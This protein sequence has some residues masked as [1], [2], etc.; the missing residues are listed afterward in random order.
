MDLFLN[1]FVNSL[2]LYKVHI[3]IFFLAFLVAL[4]VAHPQFLVTDEWVTANQL[5]QLNEGH[6]LILNEGKYGSFENGTPSQYFTAKQNYLAYSLILPLVSLPAEWLVYSFGDNFLMCIVYLWTFLLIAL[7]L[8]LNAFF[9]QFTYWGK[10][11]WTP[12]LIVAAF[13]GFF[14]NLYYYNS[15]LLNGPHSFPEILAIVFTNIILFAFLAVM[16][17]DILLMIFE[18]P[19]YAIFGTI[20]CLS[21]SSYLFWTNFC[22]DHALIAFLFTAVLLMIIK[23]L[24]TEYP[25][26]LAGGFLLCGLLVWARPELGFFI[27]LVMCCFAVYFSFGIQKH[28]HT[29]S[30]RIR[31]FLIPLCVIIG[32]IPF[33]INNFLYTKNPFLPVFVLWDTGMSSSPVTIA[34][35]VPLQQ[36]TYDT[37]GPLLHI[38]QA[39]TNIQPSTFLSDLFGVFFYPAS[40]LA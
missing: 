11:Q 26:Y 24:C 19:P 17:Y 35:T 21:C 32:A 27:F 15:Y 10:W 34:D 40:S 6:Q 36:N 37:L 39:G 1:S 14:L 2:K 16:V 33:F 12:G 23:F 9:P 7:A 20:V 4:T 8:T 22:K 29:L 30:D 13:V 31:L 5:T 3:L 18:N 25:G 28:L 38:I